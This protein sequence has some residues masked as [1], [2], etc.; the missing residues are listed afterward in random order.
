MSFSE[1]REYNLADIATFSQGKQVA[2]NNQ[3]LEKSEGMIRFVRIVDFTK[4]DEPIRY[5]KDFGP[6]YHVSS[7]ELVMIRYGSKTAGKVVRG[8]SGIIANNMFKIDFNK[9]V[10]VDL[11]FA[12]FSQVHFSV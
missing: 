11:D 9:S 10:K 8:Y 2:T 1:W 6:S 3:F 12:Y 4:D 7:H 5:I